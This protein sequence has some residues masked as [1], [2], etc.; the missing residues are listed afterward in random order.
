MESKLGL[1][2][3]Q[4]LSS[5]PI[6]HPTTLDEK[7]KKKLITG[8]RMLLG[9][10]MGMSSQPWKWSMTRGAETPSDTRCGISVS[11]K[12]VH[13][14]SQFW[15]WVST[16]WWLNEHMDL[17]LC[18]GCNK[19]GELVALVPINWLSRG[20]DTELLQH[21]RLRICSYNHHLSMSKR[22]MEAS[23]LTGGPLKP[24][25]IQDWLLQSARMPGNC[26]V[27]QSTHSLI[28]CL[29]AAAN[30]SRTSKSVWGSSSLESL[31]SVWSL[32]EVG[33]DILFVSSEWLCTS[34][35]HSFQTELARNIFVDAATA[36]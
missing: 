6:L 26:A 14:Y 12:Y 4:Q 5:V 13:V 32:S 27:S 35:E 1:C 21:K 23:I 34:Q 16:C 11:V 9:W 18:Y 15:F 31:S 19:G 25:A 17:L 20:T 22:E 3:K 28:C 30:T 24:V 7:K 2:H 10:E 29:N 8:Q 33:G 36:G